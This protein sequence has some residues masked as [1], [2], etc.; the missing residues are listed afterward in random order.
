M[1]TT[2]LREI[3]GVE[4]SKLT[5]ETI[6]QIVDQK[7]REDTDLDFKATLY[8]NGDS[9][10]RDLAGDVAALANTVG[11]LLLLG[12][13]EEDGAAIA[14]PGVAISEAEVLRMRQILASF[15]AVDIHQIERSGGEGFYAVEVPRSTDAPHAVRVNTALR[16]PRRDGQHIRWLSENEIAAAYRTRFEIA[17]TQIDILQDAHS[18]GVAGLTRF[19]THD[20]QA[21]L[22]LTM[23]PTQ[24]GHLSLDYRSP[25]AV[26]Q[27]LRN[28]NHPLLAH[29][30][31]IHY[32]DARASTGLRRITIGQ[33]VNPETS[34]PESAYWELHTDGRGFGAVAVGQVLTN[35][36]VDGI[37]VTEP[38]RIVV[39]DEELVY[40]TAGI[41]DAL[42]EHAVTRCA[43]SGDCLVRLDLLSLSSGEEETPVILGHSRGDL[44]SSYDYE[45]APGSIARP[46]IET[47]FN[48]HALRSGARDLLVAVHRL[49]TDVAQTLGRASCLQIDPD[50]G[51]R[52]PYIANNRRDVVLGWAE[53]NVSRGMRQL[54]TRIG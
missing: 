42:A 23:I 6:E 26:A 31:A 36:G 17:R 21:W 45:R 2:R 3:F 30:S 9:D 29:N 34:V 27:E 18:D 11:G 14:A 5:C 38:R 40:T 8:G 28:R 43:A 41:L 25:Q 48:L 35:R 16:Y 7:V 15:V 47:T 46:P 22:A 24:P 51:L 37:E 50:G 49:N 20:T 53:R 13:A 1:A 39:D 54:L 12:V 10:R 32:Y 52:R 4:P 19:G 44:R 33:S